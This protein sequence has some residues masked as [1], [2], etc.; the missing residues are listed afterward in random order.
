MSRLLSGA[1]SLHVTAWC[2]VPA[3]FEIMVFWGTITT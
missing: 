2:F 3:L 1:T